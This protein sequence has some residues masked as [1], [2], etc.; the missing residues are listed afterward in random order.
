MAETKEPLTRSQ[1]MA[2]I[3]SA[4][5]KPELV[6]RRG[7]H[8]AGFRFRL[9]ARTLPGSPDIVMRKH[10]CA[11]FVHGCFWHGHEGCR[12][13]RIP[14]SRPEFWTAKIDGNRERDLRS[15]NALLQD[16]WRVLV[17]WECATRS[18]YVD[19]LVRIIAAWLQSPE[20]SAELLPSGLSIL[21]GTKRGIEM[22]SQERAL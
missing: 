8:A 10:R 18:I 3:R 21:R 12:N 9:H 20:T 5:T 17:V 16:D 6:L 1:M 7:L 15:I 19:N 22:E 11:I 4:D 2:R 14:R 13:F